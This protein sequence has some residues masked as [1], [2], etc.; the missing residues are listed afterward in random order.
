MLGN[1]TKIVDF[2][3]SKSDNTRHFTGRPK[4]VSTCEWSVSH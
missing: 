4:R 2:T 3:F 1:S